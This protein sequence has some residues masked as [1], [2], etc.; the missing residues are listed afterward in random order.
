MEKKYK[1]L[2]KNTLFFTIS[3]VGSS[4]ISFLLVPI[5]TAAL[6]TGEYGV[7]DVM[8]ITVLLLFYVFSLDYSDVVARYSLDDIDK[9]VVLKN[10]ISF[11]HISIKNV[12]A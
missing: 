5:Y 10:G 2:F 11:F 3:S 12:F 1:L 7:V 6:S 9:P 4:L 8:D